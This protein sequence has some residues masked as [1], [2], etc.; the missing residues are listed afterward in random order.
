VVNDGN[1]IKVLTTIPMIKVSARHEP[2]SRN[3]DE[4]LD[5]RIGLPTIIFCVGGHNFQYYWNVYF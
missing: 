5:P 2:K 3:T 1:L 4:R